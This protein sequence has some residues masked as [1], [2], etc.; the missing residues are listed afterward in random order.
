MPIVPWR[1]WSYGKEWFDLSACCVEARP[2]VP[3]EVPRAFRGRVSWAA[4]NEVGILNCGVAVAGSLSATDGTAAR[5][6][7]PKP[8]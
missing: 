6:G 5:A 8:V 1:G 3:F 2:P 4:S 7:L